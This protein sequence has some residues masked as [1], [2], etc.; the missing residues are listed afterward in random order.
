MV[1]GLP[2]EYRTKAQLKK[3]FDLIFPGNVHSA[4]V[5]M[6]APYLNELVSDRD[7]IVKKLEIAVAKFQVTRDSSGLF[8]KN[9]EP[10]ILPWG[11]R[12]DMILFLRDEL[13]RL[14][15][16]IKLQQDHVA[17]L[18]DME[19]YYKQKSGLDKM[20]GNLKNMVTSIAPV[21]Y[22]K[23]EAMQRAQEEKERLEAEHARELDAMTKHMLDLEAH[24]K[25]IEDEKRAERE[26]IRLEKEA[27]NKRKIQNIV[28]EMERA[29]RAE[30]RERQK[31]VNQ[32]IC[33]AEDK[34]EQELDNDIPDIRKS[35]SLDTMSSSAMKKLKSER[36]V[37]AIKLSI[38][39][40]E[41]E[42][43]SNSF[44]NMFVCG[45]RGD[46]VGFYESK[47]ER[48]EAEIEELQYL[49][50]AGIEEMDLFPV[51]EGLSSPG[52]RLTMSFQETKRGSNPITSL[53]PFK[54]GSPGK[55]SRSTDIGNSSGSKESWQSSMHSLQA[56]SN[57]K[58][59]NE[60]QVNYE[61]E[62]S[63][64]NEYKRPVV[65]TTGFVT[66]K[67][68]RSQT[69]AYQLA[70]LDDR[71]PDFKAFPAP[72]YEDI[73]W[74]NIDAPLKFIENAS[75]ATSTVLYTGLLFWGVIIAFITTI[76]Q[77]TFLGQY[78][79]FFNLLDPV[80]YAFLSGILPVA[81]MGAFLAL[82]PKI[83][84]FIAKYFERQK[85]YSDVQMVVF[86][87][88]FAY[89]LANVYLTLLSGSA[90]TAISSIIEK[91]T[92]V[93]NILGITLPSVS[94]FFLNYIIAQTFFG[95]TIVLLR[96]P[97]LLKWNILYLKCV[98]QKR[99]T[100]RQLL[101]DPLQHSTVD[102]GERTPDILFILLIVQLYWVITPLIPFVG[103]FFFAG[104][105]LAYKYQLLYV[106]VPRYESGGK[107]WYGIFYRVNL[108]LITSCVA[109]IGY[110]GIKQG[111]LQVA[112]LFP[113]PFVIYYMWRRTDLRYYKVSTTMSFVSADEGNKSE[114]L[115]A[116]FDESFF[117][118]RCI[119]VPNSSKLLIPYREHDIPLL[120]EKGELN[121][122]YYT[123]I[124]HG[125]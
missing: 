106:Y 11:V 91:P 118:Q 24:L 122:V 119:T 29:E 12:G 7:K 37:V 53:S 10:T 94:I 90:V 64:D 49:Q 120:N 51:E 52:R 23:E 4:I 18:E 19:E 81:V 47:L 114:E 125:Q 32:F 13:K 111:A 77:L 41:A 72:Q 109:M 8:D 76:S 103:I 68:R 28:S 1:E 116:S 43:A 110:M 105:Y 58:K 6:S 124:P 87:W 3:F 35:I 98:D 104:Q 71:Y 113:L 14:D 70:V 21:D 115:I 78:I 45:T 33:R 88:F 79:P 9:G 50:R 20:A 55:K 93:F 40:K 69:A 67:T 5:S 121:D 2:H 66:F 92:S 38:A 75:G 97:D 26:K 39:K 65:S 22:Q 83:F 31:L 101:D 61:L 80:S 99:L 82:L 62:F 15:A 48:L 54:P 123:A 25:R 63:G 46:M 30:K 95:F 100:R 57:K 56:A 36:D 17:E 89:T 34:K 42:E 108:G 86:K 60:Q 44:L 27:E 102:Y 112:V 16:E 85:T 74:E 59:V 117:K 73:M 84:D 96:I 107:L